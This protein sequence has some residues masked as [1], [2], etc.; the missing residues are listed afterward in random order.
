MIRINF[1]FLADYVILP[2][3]KLFLQRKSDYPSNFQFPILRLFECSLKIAT[4]A[5]ESKSSGYEQ[6]ISGRSAEL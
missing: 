4:F 2:K 1:L 3:K 6:A 5:V